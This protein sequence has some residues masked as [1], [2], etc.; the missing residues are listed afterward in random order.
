MVAYK[1]QLS[2]FV[3]V[4]DD[5]IYD[6]FAE[7]WAVQDT[8]LFSIGVNLVEKLASFLFRARHLVRQAHHQTASP[9]FYG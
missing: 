3:W 7:V 2:Q 1:Y 4:V 9:P 6:V 5:F 8:A